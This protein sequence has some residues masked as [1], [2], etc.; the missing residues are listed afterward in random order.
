MGVT[1]LF[2]MR[3]KSPPKKFPKKKSPPEKIV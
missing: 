2:A 1:P 3:Q